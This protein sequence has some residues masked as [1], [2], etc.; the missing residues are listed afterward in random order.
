LKALVAKHHWLGIFWLVL[1]GG[2]YFVINRLPR[3]ELID[4]STDFDRALPT[5]PI[6]V[7]PY[8]SFLPLVFILMPLLLW[9][10]EKLFRLFTFSVLIAQVV[11]NICYL[12]IPATLVRPDLQGS[13]IFT[14]LLRDVVWVIDQPLNTFPSNHVALSVLAIVVLAML[15]QGLKRF[16]LLQLWLALVAVST[17][18]TH[19]HVISDLIS[20]VILGAAVPLLLARF[21]AWRGV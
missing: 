3:G 18:L 6:F 1:A 21:S 8:L 20:G 19:Q 7:V 13:D 4:M 11:M 2:S 15:P 5:W 16:W 10:N 17:L 9:R 12:L 14:V